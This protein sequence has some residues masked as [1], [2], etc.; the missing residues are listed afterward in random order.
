VFFRTEFIQGVAIK[1]NDQRQSV[2]TDKLNAVFVIDILLPERRQ[3]DFNRIEIVAPFVR[4]IGRNPVAGDRTGDADD[5]ITLR[6]ERE[7]IG[8]AVAPVG[9]GT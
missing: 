4:G 8:A 5:G 6:V 2:G 3:M 7:E 1:R 9:P